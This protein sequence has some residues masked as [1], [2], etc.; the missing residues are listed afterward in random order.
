MRRYEPKSLV[1]ELVGPTL[2]L[3]FAV[4]PVNPDA[5]ARG[6]TD[7]P[8]VDFYAVDV[9]SAT[10]RR[11][12]RL[13]SDRPVTWVTAPGRVAILRKYKNFSRGGLDLEVLPLPR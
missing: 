7:R 8:D 6:K 1:Q 13:P 3:S 9:P 5:T 12:F 11:L 2:Y 10:A 4:D